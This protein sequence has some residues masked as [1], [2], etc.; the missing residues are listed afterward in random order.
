MLAQPAAFRLLARCL[1][2]GLL[3][4][5][6]VVPAQQEPA[7]QPKPAGPKSPRD[8]QMTIRVPKGFRVN[9]VASEPEVVDPVAMAFDE[10]G[11]L[12]VAEMVGYPNKGVGTGFITSGR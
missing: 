6:A 8:E 5:P 11:R 7:K 4:A 12:Y 10:D 1:L 3:V 2:V 9:L